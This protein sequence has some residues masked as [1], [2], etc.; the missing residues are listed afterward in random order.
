MCRPSKFEVKKSHHIPLW[1]RQIDIGNTKGAPDDD[2]HDGV[3]DTTNGNESLP[4][5]PT[6]GNCD[7]GD[8]W[9]KEKKQFEKNFI[10][11][12]NNLDKKRKTIEQWHQ[13]SEVINL[14]FEKFEINRE[15]RSQEGDSPVLVEKLGPQCV[16]DFLND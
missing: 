1:F 6:G 8:D 7:D 5:K 16:T 4:A 11:L 13:L 2:S 10:F 15:I 14:I 9:R 3:P 12:N